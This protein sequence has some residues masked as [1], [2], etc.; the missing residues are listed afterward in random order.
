MVGPAPTVTSIPA[1]RNVVTTGETVCET[2][3]PLLELV[4][5][6][7]A[8]VL[9]MGTHKFGQHVDFSLL[10]ARGFGRF[11]VMVGG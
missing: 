2:R 4:V 11:S 5:V 3:V 9:F 8:E 1:L 6:V 10:H 7:V